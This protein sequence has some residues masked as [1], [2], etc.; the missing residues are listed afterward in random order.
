MANTWKKGNFG[1]S[2]LSDINR[3]FDEL[4]QHFNDW[5]DGNFT[6]ISWS[7]RSVTDVSSPS[8]PTLTDISVSLASM[9]DVSSP[10]DP[11]YTNIS[12]PSEPTYE[13]IG[14]TT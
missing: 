12:N 6:D 9:S 13:D 1:V 11:S 4:E 14:V 2:S 5:T 3:S 7:L 10:S 8:V